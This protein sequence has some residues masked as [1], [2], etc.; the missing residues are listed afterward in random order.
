MNSIKMT[1]PNMESNSSHTLTINA[2]ETIAQGHLQQSQ[3]LQAQSQVPQE[4][5]E[6]SD[7]DELESK[8]FT[9]NDIQTLLQNQLMSKSSS[10]E[11]AIGVDGKP[12]EQQHLILVTQNGDRIILIQNSSVGGNDETSLPDVPPPVEESNE[13]TITEVKS[14]SSSSPDETVESIANHTSPSIS[15]RCR[16]SET[17]V[18]SY[19]TSNE[20]EVH[21]SE[22][23]TV[24]LVRSYHRQR[25]SLLLLHLNKLRDYHKDKIV[26]NEIVCTTKKNKP[27]QTPVDDDSFWVGEDYLTEKVTHDLN[28]RTNRCSDVRKSSSIVRISCENINTA[29]PWYPQ[30]CT[31]LQYVFGYVR[32][33]SDSVDQLAKYF[34][35]ASHSFQGRCQELRKGMRKIELNIERFQNMLG[36]ELTQ[37]CD[38][39][40]TFFADYHLESIAT[41]IEEEERKENERLAATTTGLS[42]RSDSNLCLTSHSMPF[43][44]AFVPCGPS[45]E[46]SAKLLKAYVNEQ[47]AASG[48]F[49]SKIELI[50]PSSI[51]ITATS[52]EPDDNDPVPEVRDIDCDAP[53]ELLESFYTLHQPSSSRTNTIRSKRSYARTKAYKNRTDHRDESPT[54]SKVRRNQLWLAQIHMPDIIRFLLLNSFKMLFFYSFCVF[55]YITY[56][57][58]YEGLIQKPTDT[59]TLLISSYSWLL[60]TTTCLHQTHR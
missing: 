46:L 2:L 7:E 60:F 29:L 10:D 41:E 24:N 11:T 26:N 37:M 31:Q 50:T 33:R 56:Y 3:Q 6:K 20:S 43:S 28:R 59:N 16:T 9:V 51:S 8:V 25:R 34:P 38:K 15:N 57:Y 47:R 45:H 1:S 13:L 36:K 5:D 52:S 18:S 35:S 48:S 17:E 22:Q 19:L 14:K 32:R 23:R 53:L 44:A 42:T 30:L 39:L 12:V 55:L 27:S 21:L 4:N 49:I 58:Y 54:K 40:K